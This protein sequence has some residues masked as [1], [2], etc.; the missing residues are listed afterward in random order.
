MPRTNP[1]PEREQL[2][3]RRLRKFRIEVTKLSQTAFARELELD[4]FRLGSHEHARVP[5]RVG[6]AQKAHARFRLNPV[7]LADGVGPT[8][9]PYV[10]GI[11]EKLPESANQSLFSEAFDASLRS[12]F[13]ERTARI[14]SIR[15]GYARLLESDET[16]AFQKIAAELFKDAPSSTHAYQYELTRLLAI[17]LVSL[18]EEVQHVFYEKVVRAILSFNRAAD[19][20]GNRVTPSGDPVQLALDI[21]GWTPFRDAE[22]RNDLTSDADIATIAPAMS[23]PITSWPELRVRLSGLTQLRGGK[24]ALARLFCVTPQAVSEWLRGKSMPSADTT[25]RLLD[26]VREGG[27]LLQ[28]QS[29]VGVSPPAAPKTQPR[30]G[31]NEETKPKSGQKKK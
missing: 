21:V 12:S 18:P 2:I 26:W 23:K 9:A 11:W 7:W 4:S 13:A 3:C 16:E 29:A 25:I 8:Q 17:S 19:K 20:S 31:N 15:K 1:V 5:V 6:L 14:E 24:A 28:K 22:W 30:K 10:L 27:S